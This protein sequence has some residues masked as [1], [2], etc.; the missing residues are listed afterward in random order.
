MALSLFSIAIPT[1]VK[2]A[3]PLPKGIIV[4][5]DIPV[6]MRDGLMLACNV[7]RPDKPGKFPVIVSFTEFGKDVRV[8][9]T[10]WVSENCA[11]EA[12]DPGYWV[13]NDYV[14]VIFDRGTGKSPGRHTGVGRVPGLRVGGE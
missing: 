2:A 4:E 10:P 1:E 3:Y 7:F 5:K 12:P 6:T 9:S 14:V 8:D 11:F 13:P